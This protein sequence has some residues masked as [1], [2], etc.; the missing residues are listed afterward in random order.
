MEI[1][2]KRKRL[3]CRWVIFFPR[4]HRAIAPFPPIR[5]PLKE[6]SCPGHA[7]QEMRRGVL[8]KNSHSSMS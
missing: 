1:K 8:T 4:A 6:R 7:V 3:I 5:V 2:G